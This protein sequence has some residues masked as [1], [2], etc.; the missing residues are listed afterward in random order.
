MP[1]GG[2]ETFVAAMFPRVL[3]RPLALVVSV[4]LALIATSCF[5]QT[6]SRTVVAPPASAGLNV[7][8]KKYLVYRDLPIVSSAKVPDEALQRVYDVVAVM[9]AK[10]PEVA[11]RMVQNRMRVAVMAET[12][13]TTDIPEHS[14]LYT[15]FPGTDWNTRARGLGATIARPA[16]SCA[17]ENVMRYM[18][19]RY[20]GEDILVHEFAHGV[21]IMGL[22]FTDATWLTRLTAAYNTARAAGKYANSYSGSNVDEYWAE[23]VQDWFNCNIYRSPGDG[24]HIPVGNREE[25]KAYDRPLYDLIAEVFSESEL[26]AVSQI[27]PP[28]ILQ[29]PGALSAPTGGTVAIA[30]A[31][32]SN[33]PATFMWF[34]SNSNVQVPGASGQSLV[35]RNVG[36]AEATNYY[37]VATSWSAPARQAFRDISSNRGVLS[38]VAPPT[39]PARVANL[40]IRSVAG[41]GAQTLIVGFVVG[42]VAT[43]GGK[44]LLVRAIGPALTAFGVPGA[45]ADPRLEIFSGT[46]RLN[47]NDDWGGGAPLAT[48]FASVGAFPL[49]GASKDAA[50]ADPALASGAYTA[51][52]TGNGGATGVAL[53]EL[54]DTTASAGFA[55]ATPRLTNVSARTQVGTGGDILIAGINIAGALPRTVLIRAVGPGLTQFGVPGVLAD[56]VLSV[57]NGATKINLNDNWGGNADVVALATAVGAFALPVT[58]KDAVLAITLPP[59]SY[60]VQ[61][62][63]ADGGTGVALVEVY[64]VP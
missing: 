55:N 25:L 48:T 53:A 39:S 29:Q 56:P 63:G 30:A 58:S 40:S 35:L 12:E 44:G 7:F 43:T 11:A 37:F 47:Q 49:N 62:A 15:A 33:P 18:T 14:D 28:T 38:V 52:V 57:F 42:G 16:L 59:G 13:V 34:K 45:L 23:G 32:D 26:P 6:S 10:R 1:I 20:L 4:A 36:A 24:I 46:S 9:L 41:S 50:L 5:A 54:Y 3:S 51:Q 64:E 60:S 17:E 8:Y 31:V 61:V 2:A 19:D 27:R 21:D 22:R